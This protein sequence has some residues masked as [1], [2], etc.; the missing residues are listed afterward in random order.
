[1]GVRLAMENLKVVGSISV[2]VTSELPSSR[3]RH[4]VDT[5]YRRAHKNIDKTL[6][7]AEA[8]AKILRG[9]H[10][11]LESYLQVIGRW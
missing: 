10:E 8:E 6:N 7:E 2:K 4:D 11:D 5:F 1:M 3:R 9:T